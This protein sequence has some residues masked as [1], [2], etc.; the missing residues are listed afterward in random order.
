MSDPR[1]EY[2]QYRRAREENERYEQER[3]SQ[4]IE[5]M[6]CRIKKLNEALCE[7]N[8]ARITQVA[9]AKAKAHEFLNHWESQIRELA[10]WWAA[11]SE[12]QS[13]AWDLSQAVIATLDRVKQ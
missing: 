12:P 4:Y 3:E 6:Q 2:E 11:N 9:D 5:Q 1:L 7:C 8:H 10:E 13:E